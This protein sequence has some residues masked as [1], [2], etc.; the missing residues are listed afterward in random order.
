[1]S[2]VNED[3]G[4]LSLVLLILLTLNDKSNL[5]GEE[6]K[7]LVKSSLIV[8]KSSLCPFS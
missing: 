6:D 4:L 1:M 5:G 3:V 2:L 8:V 7:M